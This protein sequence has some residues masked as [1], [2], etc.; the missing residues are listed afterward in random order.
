MSYPAPEGQQSGYPQFLPEGPPPPRTSRR[1]VAAV[2]AAVVVGAGSAVALASRPGGLH[3]LPTAPAGLIAALT[4]SPDEAVTSPG[5]QV[6]RIGRA[7][8]AFAGPHFSWQFGLVQVTRTTPESGFAGKLAQAAQGHE[9]IAVYAEPG[10]LAQFRT[11]PGDQV[12]AAVVADGTARPLPAGVLAHSEGLLVS[13]PRGGTATL[14]V[15]DEGHTQSYDLRTGTRGPGA[16]A[17]YYRPQNVTFPPSGAGYTG[18][19]TCPDI[20]YILGASLPCSVRIQLVIITDSA[21]LQPWLPGLGWARRG[22]T[23]LL[24]SDVTYLPDAAPITIAPGGGSFTLQVRKSF[25]VRLASGIAIAA[26]PERG[27][28]TATQ[29]LLLAFSVPDSFTRGTLLIHPDGRLIVTG[30]PDHWSKPPPVKRIPLTV[31]R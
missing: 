13:V 23:W 16:I 25:A 18:T 28:F 19:G 30:K 15:T 11:E 20:P 9:F 1:K 2:I 22:H 5:D 29:P 21:S 7:A 26:R 6:R 12:T 31:T 8:G 10:A 3:P 24:I 27:A 4:A 14:R 17:G